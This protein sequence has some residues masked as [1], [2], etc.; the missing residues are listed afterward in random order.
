[1]ILD[2]DT[3]VH[4]V[5]RDIDPGLPKAVERL[6]HG[7][8]PIPHLARAVSGTFDVDRCD[9]LMRDSH[10]TGVR[11]GMLDLQWLLQSLRLYLP[12]G[13]TAARLAVDG[14]KGLTAV[15]GFFLGRLY[16]YRQ[17]YLHKAVRAAEAVMRGLFRRLAELPPHPSTPAGLDALLRG[18]DVSLG[19]FL[20][21]DDPALEEAI[22]R[23]TAADDPIL[24]TL[25]ARLRH[26]HLFKTMR[27]RK[28]VPVDVA[29]QRLRAAVAAA[30]AGPDYL[31]T[32][33][34]V[35]V[36]A[37]IEDDT[38]MVIGGGGRLARLLDASPVLHGLSS[39]AF[40]HYRAI[41]PPEARDRVWSDLADLV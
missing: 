11:Y 39:E 6:V 23:L 10:M 26:R 3:E 5:L 14:E 32:V 8:S 40:V 34:R 4:R 41:F 9:Y 1:L 25:A 2:P 35:E 7:E 21:L 30:D 29:E 17:V 19:A 13:A 31:A 27:L 38:M 28:D 24:R 36:D 18:A 16:M 15:E 12:P 33:D 20:E 37:Y 22:R